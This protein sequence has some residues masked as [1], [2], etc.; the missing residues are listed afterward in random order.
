MRLSILVLFILLTLGGCSLINGNQNNYTAPTLGSDG[1]PGN[2]NDERCKALEDIEI[3]NYELARNGKI[4]WVNMVE[5]FYQKRAELY[6]NSQDQYGANE[7]RAYQKMLAEQ[8]DTKKITE[9]Q[10]TYQIESKY[11][12]IRTRNQMINNSAPRQVN[13][14]TN[15]TGHTTCN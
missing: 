14:Y 13:C 4:T 11:S 10:W 8:M 2:C 7:L 5:A 9:S 6:P 1:R 3:K 15:K 12:E